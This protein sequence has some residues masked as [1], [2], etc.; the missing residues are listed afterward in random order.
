MSGELEELL[1][2][3]ARV[4]TFDSTGTFTLSLSQA[5]TKL[6][7]YQLSNLSQGVLKMLQALIQLEPSAIWIETDSQRFSLSCSEPR[8]K[9]SPDQFASQF[10]TVV[11]G[12]SCPARDM[13]IGLLAF[14][15]LE[16]KEVWWAEWEGT[17]AQAT[18][19]LFGGQ[20]QAQLRTPPQ[21][22]SHSFSLTVQAGPKPF[23][24]DRQEI[25]N[26][27]TFAPVNIL[28][29]GRLLSELSWNPPQKTEAKIPYWVDYYH[30]HPGPVSQGLALK[31]NGASLCLANSGE[32]PSD[33]WEAFGKGLKA[34]TYFRYVIGPATH[35]LEFRGRQSRLSGVA[36]MIHLGNAV[37]IPVALQTAVGES[38]WVLNSSL[39]GPSLLIPV[40]HGIVLNPCPLPIPLGGAVVVLATPNL[41]VDLSQFTPIRDEMWREMESQLQCRARQILTQL[42]ESPPDGDS[43]PE[44]NAFEALPLTATAGWLTSFFTPLPV[45][46]GALL[47]AAAGLIGGTLVVNYKRGQRQK[48]LEQQLANLHSPH[49]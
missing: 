16:P 5:R 42:K 14:L 2:K 39:S 11:L 23:S 30:T 44:G 32:S 27:A 25:S 24:L 19:N 22:F 36:S 31:P 40:Q 29:N 43:S 12:G 28:Y 13:A 41:E 38:I 37:G 7:N 26:R 10:E 34:S 35:P 8:H 4:G 17:E 45:W 49:S 9:M 21:M 6:E 3:E 47:G 15:R 33:E 20:G 1:E 18:V 48:L 46:M